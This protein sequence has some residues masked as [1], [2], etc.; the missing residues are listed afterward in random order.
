LEGSDV[1]L[2]Y[3]KIWCKDFNNF[4]MRTPSSLIV[5]NLIHPPVDSKFSLSLKTGLYASPRILEL[6]FTA[7]W[8]YLIDIMELSVPK[9]LSIPNSM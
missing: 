1:S 8:R 7:L 9:Y 6:A 2:F 5:I 4:P 3:T